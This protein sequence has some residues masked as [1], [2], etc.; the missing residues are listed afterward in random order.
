MQAN[1]KFNL[2]LLNRSR[3]ETCEPVY[4]YFMYYEGYYSPVFLFLLLK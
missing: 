3:S 2:N 4:V 1:T